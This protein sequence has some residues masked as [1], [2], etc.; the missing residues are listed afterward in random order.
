M[1][2]RSCWACR[3]R[4]N[5]WGRRRCL[6]KMELEF[7]WLHFVDRIFRRGRTQGHGRRKR[8][9]RRGWGEE[10]GARGEKGEGVDL[11]RR[12]RRFCYQ[13]RRRRRRLTGMEPELPH[14]DK[15]LQRP[16]ISTRHTQT[17]RHTDTHF[18]IN[19]EETRGSHHQRRR[20]GGMLAI[21]EARKERKRRRKGRTGEIREKEGEK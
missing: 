2:H 18:P 19:R 16:D 3:A 17:H 21:R 13:R 5:G 20:E 12:R 10:Q 4:N 11:V 1:K 14:P 8:R 6:P 7:S 15:S 9:R